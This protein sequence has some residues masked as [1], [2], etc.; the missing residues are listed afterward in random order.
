MTNADGTSADRT[1]GRRSSGAAA[2]ALFALLS[3]SHSIGAC[4]AVAGA[5]AGREAAF[6]AVIEALPPSRAIGEWRASGVT[7]RAGAATAIDETQGGVARGVSVL[8]EGE[9]EPDGSV[10]ATRIAVH[11]AGCDALPGAAPGAQGTAT[12]DYLAVGALNGHRQGAAG[13]A[14]ALIRGDA[15][16]VTLGVRGLEPDRPYVLVIDGTAAASITASE[17]GLIHAE[18][19][20]PPVDDGIA[21]PDSLLPVSGLLRV[22]LVDSSG[23]VVV[24]G[25][26]RDATPPLP[27]DNAPDLLLGLRP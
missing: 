25:E 2:L 27:K 9:T 26:L 7:V 20:D 1:G 24:S 21:L 10:T 17:S 23:A 11:A 14:I 16:E 13:V 12:A 3:A 18:M 8:V 5:A 22:E 4:D 15:H 19:S 6:C